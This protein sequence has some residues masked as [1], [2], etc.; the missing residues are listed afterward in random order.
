MKEYK[1]KSDKNDCTG[2]R[3]VWIAQAINSEPARTLENSNL[4]GD[5]ILCQSEKITALSFDGGYAEY[6]V[7]PAE[8]VAAIPDGSSADEAAPLF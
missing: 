5:F 2:R 1:T 8:A 6:M 3:V 7:A 4:R